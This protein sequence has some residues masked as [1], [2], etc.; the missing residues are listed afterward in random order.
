MLCIETKYD[1]FNCH[2]NSYQ[3]INEEE[4]IVQNKL[5]FLTI[6]IQS[7]GDRAV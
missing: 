5:L 1:D 3:I 2:E 6:V 4:V 7:Y